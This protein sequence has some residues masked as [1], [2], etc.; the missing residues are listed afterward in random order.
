MDQL[1]V[2]ETYLRALKNKY[3]HIIV[4]SEQCTHPSDL[5]KEIDHKLV[6]GCKFVDIDP[7]SMIQSTQ[8]MVYPIV[9]EHNLLP[10]NGDQLAFE[11]L[12]MIS[13]GSP[14]IVDIATQLLCRNISQGVSSHD[15]IMKCYSIL[16]NDADEMHG[17]NSCVPVRTISEALATDVVTI[18]EGSE[19]K[20]DVWMTNSEYDSWDSIYSVINECHLSTE[21]KLL[22]NCLSLFGSSP[23]PFF[24]IT[25]ISSLIATSAQK[26]HLTGTLHMCLLKLN[27]IKVHPQP[28]VYY[29][30]KMLCQENKLVYVPEFVSQCIWKTLD[31]TDKIAAFTFTH[32]SIKRL[33]QVIDPSTLNAVILFE[34]YAMLL[35]VVESNFK[36]FGQ[37]IHQEVFSF[38]L[39]CQSWLL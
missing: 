27:F 19:G 29:P 38:Y 36:V 23:I 17:V 30:E 16:S 7:L 13:C 39:N 22:L 9:K 15:T 11:S 31:N 14:I 33:S 25:E 37:D 21:E 32:I 3:V 20:K 26:Q 10:N 2:N 4:V 24:V 8:R 12:A 5:E 1:P 6:R 18:V 35:K 28:V 34:L